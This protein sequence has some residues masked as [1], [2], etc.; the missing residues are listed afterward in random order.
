MAPE[1]KILCQSAIHRCTN[2]VGNL[3]ELTQQITTAVETVTPK[4]SRQEWAA[5]KLLAKHLL[6]HKGK[7]TVIY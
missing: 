6:C 3:D 4:M 1:I 5:I 7:D 2:H